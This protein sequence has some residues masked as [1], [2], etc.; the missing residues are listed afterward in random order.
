MGHL[1]GKNIYKN[2]G[3]KI[4]NLTARTPQN[5]A[6][7][8]ILKELYSEDEAVVVAGMP[9]VLSNFKT[10]HKSLKI[11]EKKLKIL[12]DSLCEKGLV[13]DLFL[14]GEYHYMPSPMII[15]IFEFTMMRTEGNT[16]SK[17]WAKL[18]NDYLHGDG[19]YYK[20]N[21]KGGAKIGIMR[22]I[23][24]IEKLDESGYMEIL[25]YENAEEIIK[26]ADSFS[27]GICSCRHEKFHL[28]I[29]KCKVPL[30]TCSS[31]GYAA[32][33]LISHNLARKVTKEEM[34]ENL[35]RSKELGLVLNADNV[36]KKDHL[37][38]SLLQMLL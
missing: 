36:K 3:K 23:P 18:F 27:I 25:D 8:K 19:I 12:L 11:D 32:D 17:K 21:A 37:Y 4:D 20:E 22:T 15:G 5:E 34:L 2:L 33:Y 6:F 38:L 9:Y 31:F 13:M 35:Q 1:I 28:E 16:D 24:H 29:K 14:D 7:Y 26:S 30:E 10:V